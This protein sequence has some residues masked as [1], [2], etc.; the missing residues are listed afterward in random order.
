MTAARESTGAASLGLDASDGAEVLN[1][2]SREV[3]SKPE[4]QNQI[5]DL[6]P[7]AP[8]PLREVPL[9][10]NNYHTERDLFAGVKVKTFK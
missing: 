2:Q 4:R 5:E 1:D 7:G 3:D 9:Y 10:R 8:N 6:V